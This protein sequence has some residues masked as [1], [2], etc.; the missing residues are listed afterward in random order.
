MDRKIIH[1][2]MDCF[3]AAI[4]VRDHPALAGKPVGVGGA[5]DRR[6]VL[7][8]CNYE[9][10][11]Y[12]VRS[13]MPTFQALRK[14]PHLIVMPTRF[15]VYRRESARIRAILQRFTP[16]V[17]PVSLDEAYLDLTAR[18][19]DTAAVATL[20]RNLIRQQT[21]LTASAGIAPNK[22]L[23]KIASDWRKPDGQ[24]EIKPDEVP[25]FM[26]DL[27]VRRLWGIGQKTAERLS[28]FGVETCGQLQAYPRLQLYQWFGKFGLELYQLCRGIDERPV[29]PDRPRKSLSNERTFPRDLT[30]LAQCESKLP[31]LFED[32]LQDLT[33]HGGTDKIQ[34]VLVKIRFADF[35]RTTVERADLALTLDS[36][37]LLLR[38]G[39]Q[40]KTLP[41]RLLGV[42][43]RFTEPDETAGAQLEL[44]LSPPHPGRP[45]PG[46][47]LNESAPT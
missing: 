7:T 30:S 16:I 32:L 12:G 17:E 37:R 19:G 8:T 47:E 29:Q 31:E 23:A 11:R 42:G 21:G 35:T 25:A 44:N 40:R 34:G 5:R 26:H 33:R 18:E 45:G 4:E 43:V 6:G 15:D 27:P 39:L 9:A 46:P 41:V 20:I 14:C 10:R 3:Y 38:E 2:D 24:F 13:A 36:F 22:M 1:L 28:G